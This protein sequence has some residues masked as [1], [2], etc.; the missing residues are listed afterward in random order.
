MFAS[1]F[2]YQTVYTMDRRAILAVLHLMTN[3][4]ATVSVG[5]RILLQ[6]T[7]VLLIQ[8]ISI[9]FQNGLSAN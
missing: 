6:H 5:C 7:G 4:S 8:N 3:P 1:N 2:A 9:L